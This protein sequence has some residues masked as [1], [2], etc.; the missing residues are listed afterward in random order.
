MIYVYNMIKCSLIKEFIEKKTH[1][2]KRYKLRITWKDALNKKSFESYYT[3][4][5][6]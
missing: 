4:K 3:H 6:I 1:V 5:S 2:I